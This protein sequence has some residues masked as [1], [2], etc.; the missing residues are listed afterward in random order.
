MPV[1]TLR[2]ASGYLAI[3]LEGLAPDIEDMSLNHLCIGK[4]VH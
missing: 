2:L 4:L 3:E 1:E